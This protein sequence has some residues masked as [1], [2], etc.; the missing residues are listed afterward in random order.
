MGFAPATVTPNPTDAVGGSPRTRA[1]CLRLR[2][3]SAA[4]S[5]P[6]GALRWGTSDR[7]RGDDPCTSPLTSPST[8]PAVQKTARVRAF[9]I[10]CAAIRFASG[11]RPIPLLSAILFAGQHKAVAEVLIIPHVTYGPLLAP[12]QHFFTG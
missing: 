9:I 6:N 8:R 1:I 4:R 12:P 7:R 5:S 10:T 3:R 2:P 11:G